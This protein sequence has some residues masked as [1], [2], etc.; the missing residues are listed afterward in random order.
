M[1]KKKH[2]KV[3]GDTERTEDVKDNSGFCLRKNVLFVQPV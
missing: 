1:K 2:K 3:A